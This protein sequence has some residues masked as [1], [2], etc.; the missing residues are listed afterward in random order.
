MDVGGIMIENQQRKRSPGG[1]L[2]YLI[3]NDST[4]TDEQRK[5]IFGNREIRE[6]NRQVKKLKHKRKQSVGGNKNNNSKNVVNK[7][8]KNKKRKK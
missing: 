8:K 2:F 6:R 4:I 5:L 7:R 1:T 3:K